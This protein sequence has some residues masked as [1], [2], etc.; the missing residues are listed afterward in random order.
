MGIHDCSGKKDVRIR[1]CGDYR[2]LNDITKPDKYP[3]PRIADIMDKIASKLYF[4]TLD[5]KKAFHQIAIHP[6]DVQKTAITT[7]FGLFE[8][9]TMPFGLRNAA[10]MFQRHMDSILQGFEAFAA[11]YIDDIIIFSDSAEDHEQHISTILGVLKENSLQLNNEKCILG[12]KEIEFLG[13][14]I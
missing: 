5:L 2:L 13:F 8:Y 7:P 3:L 11:A 6:D 12:S 9:Q 1:P 14:R 10:Q 4:S